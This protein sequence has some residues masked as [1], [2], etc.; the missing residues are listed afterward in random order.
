M[1]GTEDRERRMRVVYR[2]RRQVRAVA[3]ELFGA[4]A[5]EIPVPGYQILT[6]STVDDALAAVRAA[7]LVRHVATGQAH[8]YALAARGAGRTWG[9]VADALGLANP[10]AA[11]EDDYRTPGE[12]AFEEIAGSG[13]M[14]W[15]P[16]LRWTCSTCGQR[17]T[18]DGPYE[19][20]PAD[21]EE[22][23]GEG[24]SRHRASVR[25]WQRRLRAEEGEF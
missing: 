11:G 6:D 2:V 21:N 19:S 20:H 22:G 9:E 23:H 25:A 13:S 4:T 18:D 24:C 1:T 7:V 17:V 10:H 15:A 16:R 8:D 14:F 12:R 3:V 5:V